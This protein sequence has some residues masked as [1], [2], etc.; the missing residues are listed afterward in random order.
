MKFSFASLFL[1]VMGMRFPPHYPFHAARRIPFALNGSGAKS[2][3]YSRNRIMQGQKR[4]QM[5][6]FM[7][8]FEKK[9]MQRYTQFGDPRGIPTAPDRH[10]A[11]Q[12]P[13]CD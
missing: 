9:R 1:S 3:R 8:D 11:G 5:R 6:E 12:V 4:R 7:A 2:G 10:G 13:L